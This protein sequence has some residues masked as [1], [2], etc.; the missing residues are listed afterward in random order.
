MFVKITHKDERDAIYESLVDQGRPIQLQLKNKK[1]VTA[2]ATER[3]GS[4][5]KLK[6]PYIHQ[7]RGDQEV[8]ASFSVGDDIY[9]LKTQTLD[10]ETHHLLQLNP[11]LHKLQRRGSF[12]VPIPD[13]IEAKIK[14]DPIE[15]QEFKKPFHLSNLSGGGLGVNLLLVYKHL[16][17]KD[18]VVYFQLDLMGQFKKNIKGRVRQ[19]VSTKEDSKKFFRLG[20]EFEDFKKSDQEA[21]IHLLA[22]LYRRI[23]HKPGF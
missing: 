13:N 14:F 7:F 15:G 23:F 3:I 22:G 6:I 19:V 18:D 16:F 9:F 12:R 5:L 1:I 11:G 4:S 20:I 21:L 2:Q 8:T 10:K 17:R